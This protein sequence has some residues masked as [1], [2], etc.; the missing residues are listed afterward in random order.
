MLKEPFDTVVFTPMLLVPPLRQN[1]PLRG[2]ALHPLEGSFRCLVGSAGG[3]HLRRKNG[4]NI[5]LIGS[6]MAHRKTLFER[7]PC[8]R[9]RHRGRM[10]RSMYVFFLEMNEWK[11]E[12]EV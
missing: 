6:S 8:R 7:T 2:E 5:S 4:G 9:S 11:H 12:L 1:M 3:S 10:C